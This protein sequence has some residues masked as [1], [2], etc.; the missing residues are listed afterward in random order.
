MRNS[1]KGFTLIELLAVIIILGI[2]LVI[3]VPSVTTYIE[4]SRKNSY[5]D[6]A[7]QVIS[8]TRNIVN[9]GNLGM[10]D[11]SATYYV[12]TTC[13]PLENGDV[14]KSP[15]GDF[16]KA[17]IV[18]TYEGTGYNYYWMSVDESGH[19]IK[20]M[21]PYQDLS[22]DQL[23]TDVKINDLEFTNAPGK[24]KIVEYNEDCS[25]VKTPGTGETSLVT[26]TDNV[27]WTYKDLQMTV[28]VH[29]ANCNIEGDYK[30]CYNATVDVKNIGADETIKSFEATFDVPDGTIL[31][32]SG[33][34]PDLIKLELSGNKLKIIGN[35]GQNTWNY[36]SPNDGGNTIASGFQIK[37]PKDKEFILQNGKMQYVE[38]VSGIQEGESSGV[39]GNAED[40]S[41]DLSKLN[42][43]LVRDTYFNSGNGFTERYT[44][45]VK[46]TSTTETLVDWSF[47]LEEQ[48]G[49]TN[50]FSDNPLIYSKNGSVYTFTPFEWDDERRTLSPGETATYPN[51]LIIETND[52]NAIPIIR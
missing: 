4:T 36:L 51:A 31:V 17:Y 7:K 1:K 6:T 40:M 11:T 45:Y 13:I 52:T 12:P 39:Q 28:D 30:I 34:Q 21:T 35:S 42:I 18:V 43:R 23:E 27:T 48:G 44:V 16:T 46:N 10:Y 20:T 22:I 9:A 8:S 26:T 41:K 25:Q 5:V 47:I 49:I 32:N 15:Y 29:L 33:Y 3:A 24:S 2:L 50:I 14:P 37:F 19:G 38:L